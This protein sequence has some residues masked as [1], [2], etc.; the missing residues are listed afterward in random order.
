MLVTT[1]EEEGEGEGE[2]EGGAVLARR[3]AQEV[4]AWIWAQR[5]RF[6]SDALGAC[7]GLIVVGTIHSPPPPVAC[8]GRT[9]LY[10]D[11]PSFIKNKISN[12]NL[13][14][15]VASYILI[16]CEP[17]CKPTL[18]AILRGVGVVCKAPPP[19]AGADAAV[20]AARRALV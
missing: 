15:V 18:R 5:E 19:R 13:N 7:F 1:E 3:V 2:L 8:C 11:R 14:R 12:I 20:A 6:R 16:Q 17:R 10:W 4:G 9:V